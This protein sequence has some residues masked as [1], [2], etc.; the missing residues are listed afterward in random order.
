MIGGINIFVT[1]TMQLMFPSNQL[2]VLVDVSTCEVGTIRL[3]I[4]IYILEI[5]KK[6]LY[7]PRLDDTLFFL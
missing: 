4:G 6:V 3:K 2:V 1:L 5:E 7:V